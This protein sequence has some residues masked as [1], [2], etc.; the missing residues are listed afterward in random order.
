MSFRILIPRCSESLSDMYK[1]QFSNQQWTLLTPICN[2][3]SPCPTARRD[4][5]GA[6]TPDHGF[7]SHYYVEVMSASELIDSTQTRSTICAT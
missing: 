1:F 7:V 3:T 6:Y 2:A 5:F 4:H